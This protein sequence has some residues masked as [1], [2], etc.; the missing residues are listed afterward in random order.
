MKIEG[1]IHIGE[2]SAWA[3][4][5]CKPMTGH[6]W[7]MVVSNLVGGAVTIGAMMI[8]GGLQE[9]GL[10]PAWGWLVAILVGIVA[11]VWVTIIVC[12][13]M[14]VGHFRK[15][16]AARDVPNPLATAY[17][18]ADGWLTMRSHVVETRAPLTAVSDVMKL[19]P[20]WALLIQG[21]P[22]F[23]P[24]RYFKNPAEE[25]AFLSLLSD[26]LPEETRARSPDLTKALA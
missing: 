4:K 2:A 3:P 24:A 5:A 14:A 10:V 26:G 25:R 17:E 22:H 12:R 6:P 9:A 20:Y 16:L 7:P 1:H 21:G 18:V 23:I 11:G 13:R 15:A 19:G 8:Q